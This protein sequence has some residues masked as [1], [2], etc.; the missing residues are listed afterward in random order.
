MKPASAMRCTTVRAV[1]EAGDG[2]P[3]GAI[4]PENLISRRSPSIFRGEN[5]LGEPGGAGGLGGNRSC[6]KVAVVMAKKKTAVGLAD[7]TLIRV[8]P[9]VMS[10]EFPEISI[11]GWTGTVFESSGKPPLMYYIVEWDDA[12]M[13]AMPAEYVEKCE[14]QQ[15]YYRMANLAETSIEPVL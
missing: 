10:P 5:R 9:G 3:L 14:A 8:R 1:C 12:T 6:G 13:T 15:L 11:A 7:G 2:C 4:L